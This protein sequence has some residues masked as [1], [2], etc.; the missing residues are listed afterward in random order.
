MIASLVLLTILL[1]GLAIIVSRFSGKNLEKE[2][3]TNNLKQFFQYFVLFGLLAVVAVGLAG[4]LGRILNQ[5][6]YVLSDQS[7][8]ARYSSFVIVGVPLLIG[9]ANWLRKQHQQNSKEKE[10]LAWNF[11]LTSVLIISLIAWVSALNQILRWIFTDELFSN[12]SL[13]VFLVWSA[14]W[15]IHFKF[16]ISHADTKK[17]QLS[18]LIGSF[19]GAIIGIFAISTLFSTALRALF[20]TREINL[21]DTNLNSLVH[22]LIYLALAAIIWITYWLRFAIKSEKTSLWFIY[23]IIVAIGGSLITAVSTLSTALYQVLV[24]LIGDPIEKTFNSHFQDLPILFSVALATLIVW[25]YHKSL[26]REISVEVRSDVNRSYDYLIA[27]IG[28]VAAAAGFITVM[29]SLIESLA[30]ASL[31]TGGSAINTLLLALTLIAVGA[32][33]WFIHWNRAQNLIKNQDPEEQRSQV[34]KVY[35]FILFGASGIAAIV[36]AI[37][38]VFLIFEDLF[39][40]GLD[41]ETLRKIRYPLAILIST[42]LIAGYHWVIFRAERD[43]MLTSAT[44]PDNIFVISPPDQELANWLKKNLRSKSR[45]W[46][47][48]DSKDQP[49]DREELF[50]LIKASSAKSIFIVNQQGRPQIINVGKE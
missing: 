4:L 30:V 28:L 3:K 49:F 33:L 21:I 39:T 47:D 20:I 23:L 45:V 34:R 38:V 37:L 12:Q 5:A 6:T 42:G 50:N 31:I 17:I 7:A 13:S 14:I 25:W 2:D 9:V 36:S 1:A 11:Y 26:L 24:W 48:L 8:L 44:E 10:S 32:P 22:G 15:L 40:G 27:A 43:L 35:L 16:A 18:F 46:I 41:I 19:I 29:V